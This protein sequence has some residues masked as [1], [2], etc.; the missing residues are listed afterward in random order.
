[1]RKKQ[2][3]SRIVDTGAIRLGRSQRMILY[4][5][6]PAIVLLFITAGCTGTSS[7]D[8]SGAGDTSQGNISYSETIS[9]GRAIIEKLLYDTDT[10]SASV[11]LIDGDRTVWSETF[12]YIDGAKSTPPSRETMYCIG[13]VSKVFAA[14]AVMKLVEK[15]LLDLDSPI[16]KY[17]PD[18]TMQSPEYTRITVRMLLYH[19]AGFAGADYR[20]MFTY[21]PFS[22]YAEQVKQ[23]MAKLRLKHA[24]GYMSVYSND[25]CT[26]VELIVAAVSGKSYTQ[27][28]QD[29]ILTPLGMTHSRFATSQFPSGSFAPGF[30]GDTPDPQEFGQA[31]G[32]GGLYTTPE[33]MAK[34]AMMLMNGG[35]YGGRQ[36]LKKSSITEMGTDQTT[37]LSFYPVPTLKYGLGWD[38]VEH[39]GLEAV[40]VKAWHKKGGTMIYESDFVVAPEEKLAVMISFSQRTMMAGMPAEQIMLHAL[41]ER[42]RISAVPAP[43]ADAPQ[44]E[45]AATASELIAITGN[46]ADKIGPL[47]VKAASD[48]TLSI[49]S[50]YN[51][52][53][54][55]DNATGLRRRADGSYSSDSSPN[56]SYSAIT[57]DGRQYLVKRAP[58]WSGHYLEA[59][60]HAQLI[61]PGSTLS[62]AWKSRVGKKWLLVNEDAQSFNLVNGMLPVLSL[63][64]I[65]DYP[66][67]VFVSSLYMNWQIVDPSGSDTAARMFMLIPVDMGRDLND[68]EIESRNGE[69]WVRCGSSIH[70]PLDTVP[71]FAAGTVT[72]GSEG[73]AE[74]RKLQSG[75]SVSISGAIAWK[76]YDPDMK[77]L[78]AA[79]KGSG[80]VSGAAAG[81]YLM[82]YGTANSSITLK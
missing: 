35:T 41:C 66:G 4:L 62:S 81:S 43:L 34:A 12:G 67:Y 24:P 75:G 3:Q 53:A 64:T 18:F 1:M 26:M 33:D 54:W 37:H 80:T 32:S 82:L 23:G 21:E 46:Y 72:I 69:E 9:S 78:V 76:L 49:S 59:A 60:P 57:A 17:L 8:G 11:A 6:I 73:Y 68:V 29:E 56:V 25:C 65:E 45:I 14:M 28:L 2:S 40:G 74:W 10:P 7:N 22:G 51:G 15:G 36:I 16:V 63:N 79:G 27:Y 48:G 20:N 19:A 77:K 50:G 47:R 42:G 31:Y 5:S 61:Q 13:S 52:S 39:A 38:T 55:T 58:K 71:A 44:A 70:R 30:V